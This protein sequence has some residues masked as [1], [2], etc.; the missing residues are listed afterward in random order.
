MRVKEVGQARAG[1]SSAMI[2]MHWLMLALLAS[3]YAC[4]ELRELFEKG[5]EPRE[6]LKTWHFMLGLSVFALVWIRMFVRWLSPVAPILPAPARWQQRMASAVH[7]LL[8][9][10]MIGMPLGGWL[11]LSAAGKPVPFFGLELP[12]LIGPDQDL[13][14]QIKDIHETV[15]VVGYGLIGL[16]A[17]AALLHHFVLRD[18]T[19]VRMLPLLRR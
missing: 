3:V 1:Y 8:Y 17:A 9:G 15:G 14:S 2:A 13:A 10:L 5:S 7:M 11:M 19:L 6:L 4:I 18:N 16:H 12:A